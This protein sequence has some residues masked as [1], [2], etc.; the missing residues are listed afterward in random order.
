MTH[1]D[2]L[3]FAS[4]NKGKFKE[5]IRILDGFVN[6]VI[7]QG[8]LKISDADETGTTFIENA[9]IKAKNAA[10]HANLPSIGD[11][12][13]IIIDALDGKPGVYSAR[14]AGPECNFDDNI[15]KVLKGLQGVA[16]SQRTA[17]FYC[18]ISYMQHASDPT[19]KIFEASWEGKILEQK[20]GTNGFGYDPIFY[21]PEYNCTVAE[22]QSDLKNKISH[23][24]KA[25]TKMIDFFRK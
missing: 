1:L 9:I 8:D 24:A 22:M 17:R 16:E 11:D 12:S 14:Y 2:K 6:E 18:V 15:E 4:S 20:T 21:V 19:P 5:I 23:R 25:L 13:G 3:V 10:Q 7:L